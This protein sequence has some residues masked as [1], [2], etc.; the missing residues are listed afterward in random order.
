METPANEVKIPAWVPAPVREWVSSVIEPKDEKE[1]ATLKRLL[2]HRRMKRVW[3]ELTKYRRDRSTYQTTGERF[4]KPRD[5]VTAVHVGPPI[6][7]EKLDFDTAL[8]SF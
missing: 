7:V 5:L 8:G 3:A 1:R 4:H 2:T 6:R